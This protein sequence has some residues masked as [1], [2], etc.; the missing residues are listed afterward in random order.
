[1]AGIAARLVRALHECNIFD[2]AWLPLGGVRPGCLGLS[3]VLASVMAA[4]RAMAIVAVAALAATAFA[5]LLV[6]AAMV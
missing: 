2:A 5:A 3:V 6:I 4:V 1:M